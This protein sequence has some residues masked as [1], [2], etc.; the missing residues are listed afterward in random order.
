M[1]SEFKKYI[2]AFSP[3]WAVGMA[4]SVAVLAVAAV[5]L[6]I[7][8]TEI[9]PYGVP[10]YAAAVA[11]LFVGLSRLIRSRKLRKMIET[12]NLADRLDAEFR[13]AVPMCGDKLRMG[14]T[15]IFLQHKSKIPAY[16]EIRK[17]YQYVHK[18]NGVEDQRELRCENYSGKIVSLCRLRT[19][20]QSDNDVIQVV[21]VIKARNP[22]VSIGY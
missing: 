1:S 22:D 5:L 4:L 8:E 20:G 2:D 6:I 19:R 16:A 17:I 14:D 10:L 7:D 18:T 13:A 11:I 12:Q 15:H 9:L 21:A 3:F